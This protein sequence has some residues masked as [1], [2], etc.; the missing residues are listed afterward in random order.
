MK[1][2]QEIRVAVDAVVFGF[3]NNQIYLLLVQSKFGTD[4]LQWA[5]P[6]GLVQNNES[7][8]DAVLREL[9]EETNVKINYLE[10]LYTF[11]DNIHRDHRNRV[12]SVAYFGIVDAT[13]IDII[14]DTDVENTDWLPLDKL[15]KLAFDHKDIIKAAY[16]RLQDKLSYQPIGFDLL[17]KEFLFSDLENLYSLILNKEIDR[18]NFRKKILSFG[19]IDETTK[20][21]QQTQGRPAKIFRF[22]KK[23][24]DDFVRNGYHFELI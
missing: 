11:G 20:T 19:F 23:K 21:I 17:P 1:V 7:L 13:K 3:K 14:A 8:K 10:Q 15:P 2:K 12:I 16:K 9:A 24:Y 5:L 18:R 22:N 6:G 4:K